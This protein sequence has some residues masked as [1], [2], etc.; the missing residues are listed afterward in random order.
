VALNLPGS[1][2]YSPNRPWV[3]KYGAEDARITADL[4]I[5]VDD[6]QPTGPCPENTWLAKRRADSVLNHLDIQDTPRKR[7]DS[8]QSP[9]AWAGSVIKTG[10]EG[11]FVLTSQE[12]WD[13]AR[14]LVVEMRTMLEIS[15]SRLNQKC[16]EQIWGFLQYVTQT[17]T[18]LTSYLLG[19]HMTIDSWQ[20]GRNS[21]SWRFPLVSWRNFEKPEED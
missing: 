2:K 9:G 10:T 4:F 13:K 19:V 16:L 12:K 15:P 11:T 5:F 18:S 8:S 17:Y 7:R 6:L 14:V 3:V 20:R 1:P 21:E